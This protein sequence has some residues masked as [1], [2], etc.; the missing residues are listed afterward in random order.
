MRV[1]LCALMFAVICVS[2][3]GFGQGPRSTRSLG[4]ERRLIVGA[5]DELQRAFVDDDYDALCDHV[6]PLAALKAGEAAHGEATTCQRDLRRLFALIRN[7]GGWRHVSAPRVTR[8][9]INGS[10][11]SATVTL[12]RH[13]QADI[14][15]IRWRGRWRLDGLFGTSSVRAQRVARATSR[16][17]SPAATGKPIEVSNG[18]GESC[19]ELS[20]SAYP[21]ISGGCRIKL[22]GKVVPLTILT[23]FGDFRFDRCSITYEVSVDSE[24]RTW[25]EELDATTDTRGSACGDIDPCYDSEIEEY[26]PWRGRIYR[27]GRDFVHRMNMCLRTCVGYFVGDLEVRLHHGP[28]GWFAVVPYGGGRS[29]FRFNSSPLVVRGGFDLS[30]KT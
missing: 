7:G 21:K 22:A 10:S 1:T 8:V 4:E 6:T 12:N 23:P 30:A 27:D 20:E 9:A 3:C 2:A 29:G 16:T 24:G 26:V 17:G 19:G 15:F 25:T 14:P 13:W 28:H 11:A 18:K 5:L